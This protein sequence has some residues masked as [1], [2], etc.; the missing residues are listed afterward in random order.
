[1]IKMYEMDS[2]VLC[3]MIFI[4]NMKNGKSPESIEC[5][6]KI[7]VSVLLKLFINDTDQ[8]H[9]TDVPTVFPLPLA[10]KRNSIF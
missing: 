4:I 5:I 3:L 1:M 8:C 6:W 7:A 9:N 2:K 10:H